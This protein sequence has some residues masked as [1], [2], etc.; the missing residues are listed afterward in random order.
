L[1]ERLIVSKATRQGAPNVAAIAAM[2]LKAWNAHIRHQTIGPLHWSQNG[3]RPEK[4]PKAI[5]TSRP[6]RRREEG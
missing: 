2:C 3:E 4:F 6:N 5:G 1:R